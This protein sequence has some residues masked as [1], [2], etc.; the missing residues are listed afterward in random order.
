[1]IQVRCELCDDFLPIFQLSKL[2]PICYKIRTILKCYSNEIILEHLEKKFILDEK[3]K[4]SWI[5]DENGKWVR[6]EKKE[7]S[8][9]D[10][11]A[12][13]ERTTKL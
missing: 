11:D 8:D 7:D 3:I 2:C 6:K 4:K 5:K 1:M 13:D 9:S 10:T 12:D